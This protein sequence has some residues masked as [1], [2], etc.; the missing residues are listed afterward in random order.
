MDWAKLEP[1]SLDQ[2][3]SSKP[4]CDKDWVSKLEIFPSAKNMANRLR[5]RVGVDVSHLGKPGKL[6]QKAG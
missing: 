5:T 1:R 3:S 2:E 4:P 6:I